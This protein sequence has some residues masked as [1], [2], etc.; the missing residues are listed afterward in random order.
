MPNILVCKRSKMM[1][2]SKSETLNP[3]QIPIFQIPKQ[4]RT[5]GFWDLDIV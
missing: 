5:F 3:K 2:N 4:F 1:R